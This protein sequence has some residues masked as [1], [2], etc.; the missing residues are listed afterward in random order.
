M[1]STQSPYHDREGSPRLRQSITGFIDV[2]G[3]SEASTT[4]SA[5]AEAVLQK[6][7]GAINDARANV[8][9]EFADEPRADSAHWALKFF[10][11][12]LAFG[13]PTDSDEA[14]REWA[15]GFVVR[16]V[17]R[18]QLRMCE[19]GFFIRGAVTE[20]PLCLSDEIIFGPALVE[21]YRLESKTSIVPRVLLTDAVQGLIARAAARG[22][23]EGDAVGDSICRD[24]DGGW[25]VNYLQATQRDSGI[26]WTAIERHK[27]AVLSSIGTTKRHDVLPKYGWSVRYHNMF[28]HW[29]NG[30]PGYSPAYRIDRSDEQSTIVRL[31][32]SL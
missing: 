16:C 29:H 12:N 9:R 30:D 23:D 18:Y 1:R 22:R 27:E 8:R 15:A 25:F 31:S 13:Y 28:C 6:V 3:F 24:V 10:S 14:S 5:A 21:A 11:D 26:D 19:S 20:G 2:L 7:A 4:A 17:Q 32:E